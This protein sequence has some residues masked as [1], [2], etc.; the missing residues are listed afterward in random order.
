MVIGQQKFKMPPLKPGTKH[1]EV[2][3]VNRTKTFE[4][5]IPVVQ[6]CFV[7]LQLKTMLL[8]H[9]ETEFHLLSHS[10]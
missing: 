8:S 7:P 9:L 10:P 4:N 2:K 3:A 5:G 1:Q 6:I